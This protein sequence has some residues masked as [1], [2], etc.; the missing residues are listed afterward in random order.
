MA[1]A[2]LAMNAVFGRFFEVSEAEAAERP[3]E[4]RV[5]VPEF[6]RSSSDVQLHTWRGV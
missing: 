6:L 3:R 2:F 5:Q 4:L 1:T